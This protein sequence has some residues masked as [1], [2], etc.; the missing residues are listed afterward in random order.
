M[1]T[2][3]ITEVTQQPRT[4]KPLC[5]THRKKRESSKSIELRLGRELGAKGIV[6]EQGFVQCDYERLTNIAKRTIVK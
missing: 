2:W 4:S 5:V 1:S 6:C 3:D